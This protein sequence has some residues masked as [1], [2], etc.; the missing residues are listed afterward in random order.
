M[1]GKNGP[2]CKQVYESKTDVFV[3]MRKQDVAPK[4]K[5]GKLQVR[6]LANNFHVA[7][8][9]QMLRLTAG[10]G[11]DVF[12]A[13]RPLKPLNGRERFF[14]DVDRLPLAIQTAS[15]GRKRRACVTDVERRSS[16][17]EVKWASE[18]CVLIMHLDS[19]SIGVPAKFRMFKD[20]GL[21][22]V[23]QLGHS[24]QTPQ[25]F[26]HRHDCRQVRWASGRAVVVHEC[27]QC[28]IQWLFPFWEVG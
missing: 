6:L 15:P 26:P 12:K 18:R 10:F 20:W 4:K 22:G 24:P 23:V 9:D 1:L 11:L 2:T 7:G 17:L 28:T 5:N 25:Q 8:T 3:R 16:E 27:G 21:M 14:V 13:E 19:G